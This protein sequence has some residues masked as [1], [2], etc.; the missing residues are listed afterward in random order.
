MIITE[1]Y[2]LLFGKSHL[3][4]GDVI[5]MSEHG[6][7]GGVSTGDGFKTI[8]D[9]EE[10]TLIDESDSATTYLGK[11]QMGASTSGASWQIKKISV[12]STV[13]TISYADG[14]NR[15]DNV[16][17]DRASLTYT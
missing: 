16:W 6:R 3:K 4:D 7:A 9:I 17:D 12:A 8:R 2:R 1:L 10:K 15:Y 14:D 5:S 13:T 11:A